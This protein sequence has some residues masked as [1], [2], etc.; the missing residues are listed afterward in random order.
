ML[1]HGF[2]GPRAVVGS[3]ALLVLLAGC[4]T[5]GSEDAE[6][7]AMQERGAAVMGVDQH[8]S[9]HRFDALEDG[10]R[11]ELQRDEADAADI[12]VIRTH[13]REVTDAFTSGDFSASSVVHDQEVPGTDVMAERKDRIQYMY[14]DLPRG[15]EVRIVT[16]DPE[17]LQ[18]I[19]EFLAFQ[20]DDHR[21]G[22]TEHGHAHDGDH[23]QGHDHE[24][25]L[26]P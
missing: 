20:R 9:T 1:A 22:G 7:S 23:D 6:F 4:A 18:A 14:R 10:G 2:E 15:G 17:A 25:P 19:H 11:I 21:A 3:V 26:V 13:L 24:G 16:R 5:T 12:E 8:T